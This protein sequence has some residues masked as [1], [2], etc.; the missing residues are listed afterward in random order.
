MNTSLKVEAMGN[1][2][3]NVLFN[4]KL[5]TTSASL[6]RNRSL[7]QDQ[8]AAGRV[9][10]GA[11]LR[12]LVLLTSLCC[13]S[14]HAIFGA[15][16]ASINYVQGNYSTP[17]SSKSSVTVKYT[18]AQ[19]GGDLNVIVVGWN[20]SSATVKSVADT[21]GNNYSLA[22]GPTIVSGS[23]TQS[24]YFAK[25]IAAAA[26]GKNTVTITFS[27]AASYPDIRVLEY[28]GADPVN[29]V[30]AV[31]ANSGSNSTS[32]VSAATTNPTD[33]IFAANI[34]QSTTSGPGSGFVQRLLT[35]PDS[36]IAED[37]MVQTAG[38][39]TASAP[40][41]GAQPWIMQAVAFRTPS[42]SGGAPV[43]P[44]ALS[45][46]NSSM[47]G[48]GT[49]ACTVILSAAAPNGGLAVSLSSSS[50]SV[51]VPS[52]VTIA[53]GATTAGFSATVSSVST[54]QSATL[55][56]S[57]N[58]VSKTFT[59][60]LNAALPVLSIS[61]STM[62]FGSVTV[63]TATAQSVILTSTGTAA[64]T[65]S[66]GAVT[67]AGFSITGVAFPLTLNPSQSAALTIQFDPTTAG[68]VTGQLALASNSSTGAST[69]IALGGTGTAVPAALSSLSCSNNSM[70]G[71]GTDACTVGLSA[72]A[73]SG[74]FS[75]GLASNNSAVAVPS[76]ITVAAGATSASFSAT[77]S[78]V[79]TAQT[80]T[81]TASASNVSETFAVQLNAAVPT[82]SMNANSVAFGNVTVNVPATQSITLTSTGG[83]PVT[84]NSAAITGTGFSMSGATFPMT[85]NSNQSAT[86]NVQFDPTVTGSA[87]GQLTISSNSSVNPA[88]VIGLS[89]T[90]QAAAYVVS[91][92]WQAP[93]S[94]TDPVAGYNI[95]RSLSG[96]ATY[97]LLSSVAETQLAY[98]DNNVQN[99]QTYD[100]IVESVDESGNE[101][102]PSNMA[103]VSIQ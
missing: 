14:S 36:D 33:L 63:N 102:V 64:V 39:Y 18:A 80:V 69:I 37:E 26:A 84:V 25:N 73:A 96:S 81:L 68:A 57:A 53:A 32:S 28:A 15:T 3:A 21:S 59:M 71:A 6:R 40:T 31:A 30:D 17:Q 101:S 76:S 24:I 100:Y 29:P 19:V 1:H 88:A 20:D 56:G 46:S 95:Y 98:T 2:F 94:S 50:S 75:V 45:C 22:L 16:I 38:S 49:D 42:G 44:S 67:G 60:Q 5:A 62:S 55:T 91:V 97:Q 92:T 9:R 77:I 83:A 48:S 82:L 51:A 34:V 58:G 89:G 7:A 87:T 79:S 47:T 65:I 10:V 72:A 103:S 74:G 61:T 54:T 78:F 86:L 41:S 8:R 93:T 4:S 52:S 99:G 23:L 27:K 12:G 90:G 43:T 11:L 35:Q 66:S 13:C 70:S 85:L